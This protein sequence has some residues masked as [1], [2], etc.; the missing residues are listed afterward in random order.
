MWKKLV[1]ATTLLSACP[2]SEA[3]VPGRRVSQTTA[4]SLSPT[5]YSH[6]IQALSRAL[7]GT[8]EHLKQIEILAARLEEMER[9]NPHIGEI[10]D[11]SSND[12]ALKQAVAET[13]AAIESHGAASVEAKQA[14]RAVDKLG[15]QEEDKAGSAS[16][17]YSE[18]AVQSHH[19]YNKIV[20]M[21]LLKQTMEAIEK[22]M[23]F[24][25]FVQV[26]EQRLVGQDQSS[27]YRAEDSTPG[28][29]WGEKVSP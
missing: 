5:D 11:T 21:G 16:D 28:M 6:T 18:S 26:E 19:S 8:H 2:V 14:F 3:F 7:R 17:R 4:L 27:S 20:D 13:K 15:R 22:I 29:P 23:S 24:E 12:H 25:H 10:S 9:R 1:V